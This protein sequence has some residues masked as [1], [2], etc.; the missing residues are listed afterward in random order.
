MLDILHHAYNLAP[1]IPAS[2]T[3]IKKQ[4]LPNWVFIWKEDADKCLV[5][6][7]QPRSAAPVARCE[8]A[9]RLQSD[10]HDLEIIRTNPTPSGIE[11]FTRGGRPPPGNDETASF[12]PAAQRQR[13]GASGRSHTRQCFE[14]LNNLLEEGGRLWSGVIRLRSDVFRER[15]PDIQ[16]QDMLRVE[17]GIYAEQANET[18]DHQPGADQE[19]ESDSDLRDDQQAAHAVATRADG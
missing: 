7:E 1:G 5:D 17:A 2:T 10:A 11:N 3:P 4:P 14:P 6:D 15:Q 16:R 18:A 9:A 8:G 19:H 12:F 13:I